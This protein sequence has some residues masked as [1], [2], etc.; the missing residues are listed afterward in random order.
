MYK[1]FLLLI[2][3]L[4]LGAISVY[5]QTSPYITRVWEYKPAPWQFVNE[6]P[7]Y[8]AGDDEEAMCRKAE[9]LI[10]GTQQYAISLGGWGGYVV[11]G[12]DHT[13]VNVAGEYDFRIWGNAFY[14]DKDHPEKGGSAE[15]GVVYVS[16][17]TNGN[18]KPD[19]KW[20]ELAGSELNNSNRKYEVTYFRPAADHVPMPDMK[21]DQTD[22][23]YILWRDLNGKRG[24]IC[25]NL[26]HLQDYYPLWFTADRMTYTGTLLPD[27]AVPYYEDGHTKYT[28]YSF[29]Y[30][31]ADN[32]PNTTDGSKMKIEWAVDKKGNAVSLPGIDFI[33]IQT[34]THQQCGW[35]GEI[36]TEVSGAED[37]HPTATI[38]TR[39]DEQKVVSRQRKVMKDGVMYIE[40]DGVV[41]TLTGIKH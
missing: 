4:L 35:I 10:C 34:G 18:G 2:G 1:Q 26:Y 21:E 19:D 36:S 30:G 14:S 33:K 40:Q 31:Y 8:E 11:V 5:G 39:I 22:T 15:P 37:L 28:M 3:V 23:T 29:S 6:L 38:P 27:N 17:D 25:K 20:Y 13:I 9:E 32:H 24:Y 7:E 12:F 41:Y 16:Y